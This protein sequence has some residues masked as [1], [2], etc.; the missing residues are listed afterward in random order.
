MS[1]D[2]LVN[3]MKATRK[4][5]VYFLQKMAQFESKVDEFTNDKKQR[6]KDDAARRRERTWA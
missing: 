5:M 3:E 2:E 1:S 6:L 4:M